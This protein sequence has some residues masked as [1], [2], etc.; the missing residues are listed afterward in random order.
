MTHRKIGI[1][2]T[3]KHGS[4]YANHLLKDFADRAELTAICRQSESEG[5]EQAK[6]WHAIFHADWR[7][8]IA[9]PRTEAIISVTTPDLNPHIAAACLHYRKPL[10]IEKPLTVDTAAAKSM[11]IDFREA[12]LPLTVAQTLRYNPIITGLR[13]ALPSIGRLHAF[14]ASH[15]LEPSTL[16]WLTD[17]KRAGGGVIFH[18]AVHVFDAIRFITGQEFIRI[19]ASSFQVHNPRL[20]DLFSAQIEMSQGLVGMVI[21]GKVGSARAG[22]YE[23]TGD[24]GQ[25]QGDQVHGMIELVQGTIITPQAHEPLHPALRP[26]L[27]DWLSFLEGSGDNPI[28]GEEGLAAVMV[29]EAAQLSAASGEW[30]NVETS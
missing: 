15:H 1:I 16:P 13:H 22:R 7:D 24:E 11:V 17:P 28:P 26:L 29:C 4:R 25:L 3:G 6:K 14:S 19:R 21:A 10:L 12:G 8:L 18:T 5:E 2:G 23:F 30:V 27:A 9:D 20:E